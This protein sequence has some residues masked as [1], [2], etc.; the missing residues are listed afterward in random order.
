MSHELDSDLGFSQEA[1]AECLTREG[2]LSLELEFTRKCN[3]RCTYCYSSAGEALER[4]LS[5]EELVTVIEQAQHLG[6]K[7][8]ILLGG[9]EPFLFPAVREI[10]QHIDTLGLSQAIFTNG[11]CL[12]TELCR[13]LFDHRVTVAVKQNSFLSAIQDELAGMTGAYV[14]IQRGLRLL[15]ESGYPDADHSLCVQT[16]ICRPN[17]AEIVDMWIWARERGITPY[18]EALTDQGRARQNAKL[19][20]SPDELHLVFQALSDTDRERF[21]LS[22]T[23]R[24]PIAGF[25][26]RRHLYSCLVNSQGFVHPCPGVDISVGNIR[27]KPLGA[28]LRESHVVRDLRRIYR[29]IDPSCQACRFAGACYGCR[30]NAYQATGSY[31]AADPGCWLKSTIANAPSSCGGGG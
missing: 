5:P 16:V 7:R 1:I 22:W 24:P 8:I 4:E 19:A 20:L 17:R 3:L 21:G 10:V 18:F 13:F 6:A 23:A 27:E 28:I 15:L 25:T 9:G 11:I 26:C 2:L 12:T 29:Q 14:G 30:G 31:L